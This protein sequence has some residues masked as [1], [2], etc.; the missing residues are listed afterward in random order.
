MPNKTFKDPGACSPHSDVVASYNLVSEYP[1]AAAVGSQI[2]VAV[3]LLICFPSA[4]VS[5]D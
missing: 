3:P 4:S 1:V 2:G 5:A